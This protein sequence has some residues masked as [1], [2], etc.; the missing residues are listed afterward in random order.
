MSAKPPLWYSSGELREYLEQSYPEEVAGELAEGYAINL[1][2]AFEQG[3][4]KG[5]ADAMKDAA[6]RELSEHETLRDAVILAAREGDA[7]KLKAALAAMDAKTGY[8]SA[9]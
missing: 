5:N 9:N 4:T 7:D 3:W 2:R 6:V 8:Q 1:Q